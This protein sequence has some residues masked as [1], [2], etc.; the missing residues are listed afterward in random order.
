MKSVF[1]T[2]ASSGLGKELALLYLEKGWRVGVCARREPSFS[3]PLK[4]NRRRVSIRAD[5]TK[6]NEIRSRL[7]NF[8]SAGP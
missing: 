6:T 7:R 4:T 1:I 2:G 5:V 8:G 3:G